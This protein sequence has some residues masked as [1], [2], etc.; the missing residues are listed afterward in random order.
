M[1]GSHLLNQ[2]H[3]REAGEKELKKAKSLVGFKITL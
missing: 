2:G 3:I 1:E